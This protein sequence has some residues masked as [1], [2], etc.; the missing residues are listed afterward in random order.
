M[1]GGGAG[2]EPSNWLRCRTGDPLRLHRECGS[3]GADPE[4]WPAAGGAGKQGRADPFATGS[5]AGADTGHRRL[6]RVGVDAWPVTGRCRGQPSRRRWRKL[7]LL[8]GR[9]DRL[10]GSGRTAALPGRV[11]L[12]AGCSERVRP[13]GYL[14]E[15]LRRRLRFKPHSHLSGRCAI[16]DRAGN[17][18]P[19]CL[20]ETGKRRKPCLHSHRSEM[21]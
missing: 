4:Q 8:P 19:P 11:C 5:A 13:L 1:P 6:E 2:C 10:G 12:G 15:G 3:Q 20:A 7:L 16:Q 14:A 9:R 18:L 21:D 17:G